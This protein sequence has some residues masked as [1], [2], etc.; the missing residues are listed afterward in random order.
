[1]SQYLKIKR[2]SELMFPAIFW[3]VGRLA[4]I[5]STM[6]K[7]DW[8]LHFQDGPCDTW[9]ALA[10]TA[11]H[12]FTSNQPFCRL[13]LKSDFPIF[14]LVQ[15]IFLWRLLAFKNNKNKDLKRDLSLQPVLL[16]ALTSLPSLH[17]WACKVC[18]RTMKNTWHKMRTATPHLSTQA[19]HY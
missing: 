8:L 17:T 15:N 3:S 4:I 7:A 18:A 16:C 5:G 12:C 14:I 2:T 9:F 6:A 13:P 1:M 19:R 11:S 10:N